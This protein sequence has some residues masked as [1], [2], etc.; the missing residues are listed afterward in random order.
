MYS[1]DKKV[2][3]CSHD[4]KQYGASSKIPNQKE[5]MI[6]QSH[7]QVYTQEG[8]EMRLLNNLSIH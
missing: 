8:K 7:F 1:V 2:N 5:S 6:Q 3:W 4:G